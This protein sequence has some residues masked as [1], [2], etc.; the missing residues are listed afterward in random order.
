MALTQGSISPYKPQVAKKTQPPEK[1]T[2]KPF[3][4]SPLV[5]GISGMS[6]LNSFLLENQTKRLDHGFSNAADAMDFSG[7]H[8]TDS[9]SRSPLK[10]PPSISFPHRIFVPEHYESGYQ[11]PLVIWLH[12]QHSSECEL[13]E[14]MPDLSMRNYVG[15]SVRATRPSRKS[16]RLFQ[17]G[18][19]LTEYVLAEECVFQAIEQISESLSI[20]TDNV[21]IAGFGSGATLAQ[22]IGLRNPSAFAGVV[23]CN[24]PFPNH[25][26]ALADW[27]SARNLPVLAM[28]NS[29]SNTCGVDQVI[30]MMRMAHRAH[31]NYQFMQFQ[32]NCTTLSNHE[33]KHTSTQQM[34]QEGSLDSQMLQVANRFMMGIVTRTP[35]T[36]Q[37]NE[38]LSRAAAST[39][40]CFASDFNCRRPTTGN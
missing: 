30:D 26:R 20:N 10:A 4:P 40:S 34:A 37:S 28:Q 33:S 38:N 2:V 27:K 35:I 36:L 7:E 18:N 32:A 19:T 8:G 13:D 1:H 16:P 29:D 24:G 39:E 17:W 22:W 21:F 25:K 14:I 3:D 5:E 23:A 9:G 15:L 6:R 11:Y 12:S 31:L